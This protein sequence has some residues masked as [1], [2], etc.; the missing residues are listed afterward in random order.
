[1]QKLCDNCGIFSFVTEYVCTVSGSKD[2]R[3]KECFQDGYDPDYIYQSEDE[4]SDEYVENG[5]VS[6]EDNDASV[7][8]KSPSKNIVTRNFFISSNQS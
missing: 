7:C 6:N 2:F 8:M 4:S 5:E 3:C 1:M